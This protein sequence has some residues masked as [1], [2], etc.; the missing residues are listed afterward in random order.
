M[1][2]ASRGTLLRGVFSKIIDDNML[3]RTLWTVLFALVVAVSPAAGEVAEHVLP[4]GLKVIVDEDQT[5]PL[6]V[7]QIWYRV[8]SKDEELGQTGMSHVLEH[9][10]FKG[11]EKYGPGEISRTVMRYGGTD[12]AFTSRDYTAYFQILPSDKIGLSY[13]IESERMRNLALDAEETMS[14]RN[15]VMEERRLRYEDDPQ[16]ALFESVIAAAFK[17]HPYQWPVIGW[18][19]DLAN[20][21]KENLLQHYRKYY[22]PRNSF[23]VVAGDISAD[24]VLEDIGQHF[25]DIEPGTEVRR[26]R[27]VEPPQEG[28]IMVHLRKEAELSY[29]IAAYHVPP[30][31]DKDS[32]ALEVLAEMLTGKSGRL[33]RSL[34]YEEKLALDVDAG[35][36]G[37]YVD[38][39]L[40]FLDA[41]AAPG[42]NVEDLEK[43]LFGEIEAI[44]EEPPTDF[45]I[46]RAKNRLEAS[47]VMGQD[48]L[49][50]R[51]SQ[52]GHHEI[53]GDWR[54]KDRYVEEIRKVTAED[55]SRAARKYLGKENRTVGILIPEEE[56]GK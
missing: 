11:T 4:N 52:I 25:S 3:F 32:Y 1:A 34:V 5:T 45:E 19:S 26:L 14:E 21:Q 47:F 27:H 38:P 43:S 41:T 48:S 24:Q 31:P 6:V 20:I 13:E 29:I 16:N 22:T 37:M 51:A 33:Y 7:F 39:F 28:E 55:V 17:A 23:I 36:S 49:F 30:F 10:M 9:M 12:N 46:Q 50:N 18:M 56:E 53:L 54:L 40:F 2:C 42:E 35:N 44:K 8:G 15:V